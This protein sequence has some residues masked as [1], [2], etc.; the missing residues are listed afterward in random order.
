MYNPLPLGIPTYGLNSLQYATRSVSMGVRSSRLL[1]NV[2]V[3]DSGLANTAL[4]RGALNPPNTGID[5]QKT[6]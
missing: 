6:S 1:A 2:S 4:V 5:L 3:L